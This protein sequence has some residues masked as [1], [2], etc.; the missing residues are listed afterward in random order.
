MSYTLPPFIAA[1][2]DACHSLVSKNPVA[3]DS[4]L[5]VLSDSYSA[6]VLKSSSAADASRVSGIENTLAL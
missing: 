2:H 5:A 3:A 1:L 6:R 4:T